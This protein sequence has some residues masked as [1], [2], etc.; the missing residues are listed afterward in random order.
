M[1]NVGIDESLH[2]RT[3]VSCSHIDQA[4][5]IGYNTVFSV[6]TEN[7][8]ASADVLGNIHVSIILKGI[9]NVAVPIG[10]GN[11]AASIVKVVGFEIPLLLFPDQT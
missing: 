6:I 7:H 1:K 3:I 10:N 5:L 2:L 11:G 8:K 9:G 4:V